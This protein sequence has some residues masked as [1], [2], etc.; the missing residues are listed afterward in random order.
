M[1]RAYV[2]FSAAALRIQS[3]TRGP[4]H[5]RRAGLPLAAPNGLSSV[6][7]SIPP[8]Y[9]GL[10]WKPNARFFRGHATWSRRRLSRDHPPALS[11]L[12]AFRSPLG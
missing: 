8:D 11:W 12:R 10:N 4:S 9:E 5:A 6:R 7:I 1:W 2:A 3:K